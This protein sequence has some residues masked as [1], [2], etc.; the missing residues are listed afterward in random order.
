MVKIPD[1]KTMTPEIEQLMRCVEQRYGNLLRTT[2]DFEVFSMHLKRTTA[3]ELSPSTLKRMWG[4]V[5]DDHHPRRSTLDVL[6]KYAGH[7]SFDD[8]VQW[9]RNQQTDNSE[10]I[11][12][13]QIV[14]S[15]LAVGDSVRI[16]W[17]PDRMLLL[18]YLGANRYEVVE[19]CNSKI[20]VGDTFEA[21]CFIKYQPL[22]LPCILREGQRTPPFLAG[23]DGGLTVLTKL[24]V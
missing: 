20:V 24:S 1:Q 8:F 18:S 9:L 17:S 11:N 19:A 7:G 4:Y 14:S 22:L 6:A 15:D 5:A 10:Y 13:E 16:G 23:R 21:G 2:T 12:L 3:S